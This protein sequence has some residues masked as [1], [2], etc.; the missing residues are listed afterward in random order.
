MFRRLQPVMPQKLLQHH[1]VYGIPVRDG[2]GLSGEILYAVDA[3]I[4]GERRSI[5]VVPGDNAQRDVVGKPHPDGGRH[6]YVDHVDLSRYE[7]FDDLRPPAK[8]IWLLRGQPFRC[9][10]SFRMGN[11]ERSRVS[12]R[13][14]SDFQRLVGYCRGGRL[15]CFFSSAPRQRCTEQQSAG[16][17][18]KKLKELAAAPFAVE[19][20]FRTPLFHDTFNSLRPPVARKSARI[21]F[22][23]SQ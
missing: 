3:W 6:Q 1:I 5:G 8:K 14:I 19:Q 10:E 17:E 11:Q 20:V 16:A 18:S 21:D 15:G 12:N 4:Y 23:S 9:V 7:R 13:Q 22:L 2:D